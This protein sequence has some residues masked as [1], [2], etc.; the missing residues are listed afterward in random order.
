MLC[1]SVV[2]VHRIVRRGIAGL[3]KLNNLQVDVLDFGYLSK[4]R[5]RQQPGPRASPTM[6]RE[7]TALLISA[8]IWSIS[9][10]RN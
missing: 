10:P 2:A 9:S 3:F 5:H 4:G 1:V 7:L 6:S 8:S